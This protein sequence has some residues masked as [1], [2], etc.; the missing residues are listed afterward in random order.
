MATSVN[1]L[2]TIEYEPEGEVSKV[3]FVPMDGEEMSKALAFLSDSDQEAAEAMLTKQE[4]GYIGVTNAL[5]RMVNAYTKAQVHKDTAL[6]T[7]R[8]ERAEINIAISTRNKNRNFLA[9][10]DDATLQR[11]CQKYEVSFESFMRTGDKAN[12][13]EAI[14]DEMLVVE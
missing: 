11:Y 9:S 2:E 10:L 6:K 13:L 1:P 14:L 8:R 12:L 7:I 4:Y 3:P 5:R